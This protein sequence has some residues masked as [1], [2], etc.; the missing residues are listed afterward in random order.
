MFLDLAIDDPGV[1]LS[2]ER[3]RH[4]PDNSEISLTGESPADVT[5]RSLRNSW[6]VSTKSKTQT[7]SRR[8]CASADEWRALDSALVS[9]VDRPTLSLR[10]RVMGSRGYP[11][12]YLQEICQGLGL[13]L[14]ALRVHAYL[15]VELFLQGLS[16][17]PDRNSGY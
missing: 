13:L 7:A 1:N 3:S 16:Q 2:H 15:S 9:V 6:H 10:R 11:M 17:L 8:A 14:G 4:V 12:G 5:F